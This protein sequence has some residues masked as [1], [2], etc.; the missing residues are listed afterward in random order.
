MTPGYAIMLR[1]CGHVLTSAAAAYVD[2]ATR[3]AG[4]ALA[5]GGALATSAGE[6]IQAP[7]D[8]RQVGLEKAV[9]TAYQGYVDVARV[10]AALP[11]RSA[12]VFLNELDRMRGPRMPP[13][14]DLSF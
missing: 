1:V 9:S 5:A 6:A 12:L 7:S 2:A 8:Q 10:T 3:F 11:S 13:P 14:P 4:R